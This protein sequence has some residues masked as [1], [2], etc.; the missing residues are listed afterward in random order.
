MPHALAGRDGFELQAQQGR[1]MWKRGE[2]PLRGGRQREP[3]PARPSEVVAQKEQPARPAEEPAAAKP[4]KTKE[5]STMAQKKALHDATLKKFPVVLT[6]E[7]EVRL[8]EQ[9][10]LMGP[11]LAA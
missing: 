5:K 7:E 3:T 8:E 6:A 10:W 2:I 1:E 4:A 11:G 9:T